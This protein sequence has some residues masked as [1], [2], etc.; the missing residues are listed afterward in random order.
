MGYHRIVAGSLLRA[1]PKISFSNA[2]PT[3]PYGTAVLY[4]TENATSPTHS[5]AEIR[6]IADGRARLFGRSFIGFVLALVAGRRTVRSADERPPP[7]RPRSSAACVSA[8]GSARRAFGSGRHRRWRSKALRR[9]GTVFL[10]GVYGGMA[11]P[12][13]MMSLFDKQISSGWV[14]PM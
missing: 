9:G 10:P 7:G 14:R 3:A 2:L 12:M 6:K 13:P 11:D 4:A 8:L 5:I 1:A